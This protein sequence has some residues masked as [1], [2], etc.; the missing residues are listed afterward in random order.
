MVV[1]AGDGRRS[2]ARGQDIY[3]VSAPLVVEAAERML[4]PSFN[5]SGA[6]ALGEAFDAKDFLNAIKDVELQWG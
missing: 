2:V 3:A 5:R 6:L 4:Q 1:Q